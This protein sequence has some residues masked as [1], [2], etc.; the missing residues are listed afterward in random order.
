[1]NLPNSLFTQSITQVQN[2][3][4]GFVQQPDCLAQLRVAF[5]DAFDDRLALGIAKQLQGGD[6]S[7]IPD[8]QVLTNGELGTANGAFAADLDQIFISSDFLERHQGDV[9]IVSELLLEEIGHKIDRVLNGRVDS[10]G[11]EGAI[12]RLLATG[13][14]L[15]TQNLA[16]LR[17]QD[18]HAVITIDGRSVAVEEQNFNGT[19]G[20]DVL[21]PTGGNNTGSDY[22]RPGTGADT[23]DG[24]ADY[25][26]L[27][28]NN[29]NDSVGTVIS[30]P[31]LNNGPMLLGTINGGSNS[32]TTFKDIEIVK[33]TTGAGNDSIDVSAASGVGTGAT[34]TVNSGAGSDIIIGSLIGTNNLFYYGEAGNDE[35]YGGNNNDYISGGTG[36][37]LLN[38][39]SGDDTIDPGTGVDII[40]GG[41]DYDIL[42]LNNASDNAATNITYTDFS[43]GTITGGV[44]N[45]TRFKNI[46]GVNITTGDGNDYINVAVTTGFNTAKVSGGGG[47]DTIVGSLTGSFNYYFGD[48]GDDNITGGNNV[49]FLYGGNGNDTLNGGTGVDSMEGGSGDD[50]YFVD[51]YIVNSSYLPSDAVIEN[52][53]EGIDTVKSSVTYIL[54]ANVEN[55]ILTGTSNIDGSGNNLDNTI[56]GNSDN[57]VLQGADGNDTLI[58]GGGADRLS[59]GNGDDTYVVSRILGGGTIIGDAAGVSDTLSLIGGASLTTTSTL[60]DGTTLL[61]DLNQDSLFDSTIDLSITNFFA[62]T[63]TNTA[64]NGFIENLSGLSGA[65][66]LNPQLAN[67][68]DFNGDKKSDILWRNNNNDALLL[69]QMN[70]T[71]IIANELVASLPMS[72]KNA[73]TGDFNGDSKSD[74]VWRNDNGAV[75][76]WQMNGKTAELSPIISSDLPSSWSSSETGDFN[77]DGKSDI[78]WRNDNGAVSVWTM[79]G[80]TVTN[81]KIIANDLPSNSKNAGTGDFNGDGKSDLLWRNGNGEVL[82]WQ[83]NGITVTTRNTIASVSND[84]KNAGTGDFNGDGK[85]DILWRNDNGAVALWQMNGNTVVSSSIV[86]NIPTLSNDWQISGIGDSNSDGRADIFW[87]N[88]LTGEN[89]TWFMNGSTATSGTVATLTTDWKTS[90][91]VI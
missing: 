28:I 76:V 52:F 37:D 13:Q 22:F 49:D 3:L 58:G 86:S 60:R 78:L 33:F 61:I 8:I 7:L 87:R 6:F 74:I 55:L 24:G 30:Y 21:P 23:I 45:G 34:L 18:D 82:L 17:T 70:G 79:D 51:T 11:D 65:T 56:T 16:R 10:P 90:A 35:I 63:I 68:N 19:P 75:A 46:E 81:N 89:Q 27:E 88:G 41:A 85:S 42:E 77:G 15:S 47:S 69:W 9:N 83:T 91:P 66:I 50:T 59:A 72:W 25:D 84:W 80:V 44:N 14:D 38:G 2:Q 53:N 48:G 5:G 31:F 32:G 57:N 4:Q 43:N 40:D 67:R 73:G 71:N 39:G 62:N 12:F 36:N 29:S 20:N 64:G 54:A 1:M 26:I